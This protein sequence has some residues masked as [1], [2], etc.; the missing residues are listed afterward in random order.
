[1]RGRKTRKTPRLKRSRNNQTPRRSLRPK[2]SL[3][4]KRTKRTNNKRSNNKRSNN[5]RSTNKKRTKGNSRKART[6]NRRRASLSGGADHYAVLGIAKGASDDAIKKAYHKKA[7]EWHPDRNFGNEEKAAV[8]FKLVGEAY[9]V[10]SDP[11]KRAEYDNPP[12]VKVSY[13]RAHQA[14]RQP[15]PTA[16]EDEIKLEELVKRG[17]K[18]KKEYSLE[19]NR[20]VF[21][22]IQSN[23]EYPKKFITFNNLFRVFFIKGESMEDPDVQFLWD[24]GMREKKFASKKMD[25][26]LFNRLAMAVDSMRRK[27]EAEE[28]KARVEEHN[29]AAAEKA[30]AAAEKAEASLL[31]ELHNAGVS[32]DDNKI[33]KLR[34]LQQRQ[35]DYDWMEGRISK[36]DL[37]GA[38]TMFSEEW[39]NEKEKK[40]DP[41]MLDKLWELMVALQTIDDPDGLD[42]SH[43]NMAD[44]VMLDWMISTLKSFSENPHHYDYLKV[45]D[46]VVDMSTKKSGKVSGSVLLPV[47]YT[48]PSLPAEQRAA[49]A[50]INGISNPNMDQ[51]YNYVVWYPYGASD[52]EISKFSDLRIISSMEDIWGMN[53]ET[54]L[55]KAETDHGMREKEVHSI[56]E[57]RKS[58]QEKEKEITGNITRLYELKKNAD[59][60]QPQ[61]EEYQKIINSLNHCRIKGSEDYIK[62]CE[63]IVV[64]C[65]EEELKI[66]GITERWNAKPDQLIKAKDS[67]RTLLS[68]HLAKAS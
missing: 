1:M 48:W 11:Q 13:N 37:K 16:R 57:V 27:V 56:S 55:S 14:P 59:L 29:R 38:F 31:I 18:M 6:R 42:L 44:N 53:L 68:E 58:Q 10:L 67:V 40:I 26:E 64:S 4:K 39:P 34:D 12:R 49:A 61:K 65:I 45:G 50:Y 15:I 9:S 8:N 7:K 28:K 51:E 36:D 41:P 46:E 23:P 63:I 19:M 66:M 24:L 5:K 2:R 43:E 33:H 32:W 25:F 17:V 60:S 30:V 20:E 47:K 21:K 35:G 22:K 62:Y 52:M 54:K 3:R